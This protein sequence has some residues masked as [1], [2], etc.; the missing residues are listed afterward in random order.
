MKQWIDSN[1]YETQQSTYYMAF[2]FL[3]LHDVAARDNA[4]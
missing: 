4:V 1:I 3:T 2:G